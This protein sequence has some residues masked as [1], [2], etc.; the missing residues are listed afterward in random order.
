M[1]IKRESTT[2]S[3]KKNSTSEGVQDLFTSSCNITRI[4]PGGRSKS[5]SLPA[6]NAPVVNAA[7]SK[8]KKNDVRSNRSV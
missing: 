1:G 2:P 6:T 8:N 3:P 4:G 5:K 7:R